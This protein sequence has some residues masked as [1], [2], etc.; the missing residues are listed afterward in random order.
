MQVRACATR[1]EHL[2]N[3]ARA[4]VALALLEV[5]TE[6]TPGSYPRHNARGCVQTAHRQAPQFCRSV[7]QFLALN[8]ALNP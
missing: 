5:S 1:H 8:P 6:I 7:K 2:P 3:T 4:Y